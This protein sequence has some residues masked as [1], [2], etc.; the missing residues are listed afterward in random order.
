[1]TSSHSSKDPLRPLSQ[2]DSQYGV[3]PSPVVTDS[4]PETGVV[5]RRGR[6]WTKLS[7]HSCRNEVYDHSSASVEYGRE[8]KL[9]ALCD[10][11]VR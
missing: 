10:L 3:Y 5:P 7:A 1:M 8:I 4:T 2:G 9:C 11:C 6:G